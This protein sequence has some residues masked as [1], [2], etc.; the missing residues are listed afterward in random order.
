MAGEEFP[1][2][3][4][5]AFVAEELIELIA[6]N[7]RTDDVNELGR[8]VLGCYD[9]N[10]AAGTRNHVS[11]SPRKCAGLLLERCEAQDEVAALLKL[12]VGESK[13]TFV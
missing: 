6:A 10:E 3:G 11:L 8:L 5:Q 9:S 4:E 7:F 2:D 13:R 12:V 1:E